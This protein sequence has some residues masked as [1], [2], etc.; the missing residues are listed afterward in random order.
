MKRVEAHAA[1]RIGLLA[2]GLVFAVACQDPGTDPAPLTPVEE[3][4]PDRPS[5]AERHEAPPNPD[6]PAPGPIINEEHYEADGTLESR[7]EAYRAA[8]GTLVKHGKVEVYF[9][10]GQKESEASYRHGAQHGPTIFYYPDGRKKEETHYKAGKLHGAMT[11]W[12][13]DGRKLYEQEFNE[14][15]PVER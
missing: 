11:V 1:A 2:L 9:K 13:P 8:D 12:G 14:G 3:A 6:S 10:N 5:D 7:W 15:E 4:A